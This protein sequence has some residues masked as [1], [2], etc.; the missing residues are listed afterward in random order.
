MSTAVKQRPYTTPVVIT[1]DTDI[2]RDFQNGLLIV[3][4]VAGNVQIKLPGGNV[5]VPVNV[6]AT[7]L[8]NW[9]VIGIVSAG[10]TATAVYT[11]LKP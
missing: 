7:L 11:A 2:E 5:T 10:T 3:C 9:E 4:S 8:D 1:P 6:G